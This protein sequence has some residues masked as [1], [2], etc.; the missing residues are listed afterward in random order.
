[1]PEIKL[2]IPFTRRSIVL[3]THLSDIEAPSVPIPV[4]HEHSIKRTYNK[5]FIIG[6]NKTGTTSMKNLLEDWGFNLGNQPAAEILALN[7]LRSGDFNDIIRYCYSADAFQDLPFSLPGLHPVLD[8][9][10]PGSKFILTVR[11]SSNEWFESLVRYHKKQVS[12]LNEN[13]PLYK[14]LE[15]DSYRIKGFILEVMKLRYG[16]SKPNELYQQKKY[17]EIH[18]AN[19]QEKRDYFKDRPDDFL[20]I[21]LSDTNDFGRL[22]KF[23]SINT[24]LNSF[25]HMNESR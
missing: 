11:N 1:M 5:V 3:K 10:F 14:L 23:L 4:V 16:L 8:Q 18:E 22:V 24:T 12:T 25:P 19:N 6:D 2:P 7:W 9:A 17:I 21:N 13:K 15:N 20:E